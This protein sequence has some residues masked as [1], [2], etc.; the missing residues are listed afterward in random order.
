MLDNH[1]PIIVTARQVGCSAGAQRGVRP[2][3]PDE[4][5]TRG[6]DDQDWEVG[7]EVGSCQLGTALSVCRIA[8]GQ[9]DVGTAEKGRRGGDLTACLKSA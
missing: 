9:W 7:H 5:H 3:L 6:V 8:S 4:I 1:W 2:L